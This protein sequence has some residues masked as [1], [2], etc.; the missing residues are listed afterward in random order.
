MSFI[1]HIMA[2]SILQD[3]QLYV[4]NAVIPML[5]R[6]AVELEKLLHRFIIMKK[7]LQEFPFFDDQKKSNSSF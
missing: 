2:G 6:K 3:E 1:G 5:S 7:K 4:S